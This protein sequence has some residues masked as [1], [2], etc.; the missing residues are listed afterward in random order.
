MEED[1]DFEHYKPKEVKESKVNSSEPF[2]LG[3]SI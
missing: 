2:D 1:G 3:K